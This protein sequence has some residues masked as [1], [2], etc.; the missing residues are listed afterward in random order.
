MCYLVVPHFSSQLLESVDQ[1]MVMLCHHLTLSS[2]R[3][4]GQQV[5]D[6][7]E[8]SIPKMSRKIYT[9]NI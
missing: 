2:G 8:E 3:D 6:M 1:F 7:L 4:D 5:E 9:I